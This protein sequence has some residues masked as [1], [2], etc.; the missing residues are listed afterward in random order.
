MQRG[1]GS[2]LDKVLEKIASQM[3]IY[4]ISRERNA[5]RHG[6]AWIPMK[7]LAHQIDKTMKNK[8]SSMKYLY[9]SKL[10]GLLRLWFEVTS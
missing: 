4:H 10:E 7:K 5:Q 8:I 1:R 9:G 2:N 3:T 6:K